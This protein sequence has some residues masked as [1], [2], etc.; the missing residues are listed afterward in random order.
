MTTPQVHSLGNSTLGLAIQGITFGTTKKKILVM[1]GLHGDEV[2]GVNLATLLLNSLSTTEKKN[3][4]EKIFILSM[5]N[6]DHRFFV[7]P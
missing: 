5:V 3:L 7:R 1:S 4:L 2:E 6:P